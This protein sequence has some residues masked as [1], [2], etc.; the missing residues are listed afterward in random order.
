MRWRVCVGVQ[1]RTDR[2]P[3]A[4]TLS[5]K[6]GYIEVAGDDEHSNGDCLG[7]R[8]P[9][10]KLMSGVMPA[11]LFVQRALPRAIDVVTSLISCLIYSDVCAVTMR[12]SF[13]KRGDGDLSRM[14]EEL[15]N[16]R[17]SE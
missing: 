6:S 4:T 14:E 17:L 12:I 8:S 3:A 15:M 5:H 13:P 2:C 11:V 16:F 7:A 1:T 10:K 9:C